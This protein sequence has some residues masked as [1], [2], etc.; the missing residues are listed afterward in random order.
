MSF[1]GSLRSFIQGNYRSVAA[2]ALPSFWMRG[3]LYAAWYLYDGPDC[4]PIHMYIRYGRT[5]L[6][7][8]NMVGYASPLSNKKIKWEQQDKAGR[9]PVLLNSL[10]NLA[11]CVIFENVANPHIQK[12]ILR[13]GYAEIDVQTFCSSYCKEFD[14]PPMEAATN[15]EA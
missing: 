1:S 8:A 6:I 3:Q 13:A 4:A 10:D 5:R 12:T 11:S 7:V 15:E 9:M 14:A 2:R